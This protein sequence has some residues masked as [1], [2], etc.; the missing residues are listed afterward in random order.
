MAKSVQGD[1]VVA[2]I[3]QYEEELIVVAKK[4]RLKSDWITYNPWFVGPVIMTLQLP[5]LLDM[6]SVKYIS[7]GISITW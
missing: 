3:S 5:F 1:E 7:V 6:S 2:T 4:M